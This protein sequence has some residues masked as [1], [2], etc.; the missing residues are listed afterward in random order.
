[1]SFIRKSEDD[2][3]EAKLDVIDWPGNSPDLSPV[4]NL[5]STR[6]SRL[7]KFVCTTM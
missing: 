5:W 7:Q 3:Q 1:V 2:F 4:E 6:K